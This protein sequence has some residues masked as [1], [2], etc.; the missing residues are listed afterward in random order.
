MI[1]LFIAMYMQL[2][3]QSNV[4]IWELMNR[5]DLRLTEIDAMANRHFNTVGR[6]RG[7]GYTQY[8][9][10]KFEM[11]FHLDNDGFILPSDRDQ[12]QYELFRSRNESQPAQPGAWTELG[13]FS[14]NRTTA[15]N[16][17]V[18]R[19]TSISVYPLNNNIIYVTSPGGGVWKSISGGNQWTPLSD[20][21]NAM[22]NMFSV[23][24]D[25]TNDAVVF[26]GSSGGTL[27]RSLDGGT[28]WTS[29]NTGMGNIRKILF[30]PTNT[31]MLVAASTEG[32]YRSTNGGGNW[33]RML[34][35][36]VEDIEFQPGNTNVL[37]A[38]G[39]NVYRSTDAG[40]NWTQLTSA[41]GITN[42]ARTLI[43]VSP[44]D[45]GI[46]YAV[47][48]NGGSEFGRLYRSVDGGS[49]FVT[50][51][52]GSAASCTNFFGYSTSGCDTGG[53]AS[54]DMAMTVNPANANEVHIGGIICWKSANGGNSFVAETAWSLPN[55]IGYNH[56]DVHVLEWVGNAI[57]SG[58]DG[59]IFRS[60]DNGDNWTDL[61]NGLGVRQFYRIANAVTNQAL[62][63]GGAQ[64]NGSSILKASG[65]ID[66]LGADGMDCVVSPLNADYIWGTSQY[67]SLYRT[68]N[69]GTSYAGISEPASGNWVTPLAIESTSNSIYAGWNDVYK[70]TDLG[71]TWTN[72]S[73]TTISS[74][75]EE[76]AVAPSN[77][78]YIY[79]SAGPD[80]Y[81]TKNG[82]TSW[83]TYKPG[84]V[85]ISSIA[86]H[87]S[88]PERIWISSSSGNRVMVSTDAGATFT[89]MSGN[90]PVMAARSIVVDQTIDEGLYVGMNVGVF[91]RNR[92]AASWIDLSDNLPLVAV[93]EV[94]LQVSGGKVRVGTYGRGLWERPQVGGITFTDSL[95]SAGTTPVKAAHL[96]EL[97]QA[98]ASLRTRAGLGPFSWTDG[99]IVAGSTVAK[100]V[101]LT[102]MRT[103]LNA[104][105]AAA[106]LTPPTY[107]H[108]GITGGVTVITAVD[109]MELR[110]AVLAIW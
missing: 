71:A 107:T 18:G 44:A 10:W 46:V 78:L 54:Y 99:S 28:A 84:S 36:S 74:K 26:A 64:D 80:L 67:G 86:I 29:Q 23:S 15:W 88:N 98:I 12:T 35:A 70:S 57:Y 52:T 91:Y 106:D 103:A 90:L 27:Y 94:E 77:P 69:G 63:T 13:P 32:V 3:A 55:A 39:S 96:S 51:I 7:T 37:Y 95:L 42:S 48:S 59:G 104:V 30:N 16:P 2:S 11:Q 68:T 8:E 9:R 82:G 61:S 100:A 5:R 62:V 21:N 50:T 17:G 47:Q 102:E 34:A 76:L 89:D 33:T 83:S 73:G 56:A 58:S 31:Q 49:S 93:N 105:Y 75:L 38:S 79:A 101:H 14:W 87:P 6:V 20:Y 41:N 1:T 45:P 109:I 97:R 19:L 22:M 85:S 110:A 40:V 25:P 53:Q 65:W 24:V 81:V 60:T 92:S 66:W 43:A 4:D 108:A 72:L